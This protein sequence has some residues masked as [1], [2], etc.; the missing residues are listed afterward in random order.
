MP[1]RSKA[2][3][4]GD[5]GGG[6]AGKSDGGVGMGKPENRGRSELS[7]GHQKVAAGQRSARDQAPGH[8]GHPP[9]QEGRDSGENATETPELDSFQR[10][11]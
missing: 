1:G 3:R 11:G 6:R 10:E 4:H 2:G 9:G 7:P 5:T 8:G